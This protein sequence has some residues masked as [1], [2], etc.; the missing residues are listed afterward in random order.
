MFCVADVVYKHLRLCFPKRQNQLITLLQLLK[1]KKN[2]LLM[3]GAIEHRLL[4]PIQTSQCHQMCGWIDE[5]AAFYSRLPVEG[6]RNPS[7]PIE[8]C[9][10]VKDRRLDPSPLYQMLEVFL[11]FIDIQRRQ[12]RLDVLKYGNIYSH[13][14][15][16]QMCTD[17]GDSGKCHFP[18]WGS[19]LY[20]GVQS[21]VEGIEDPNGSFERDA[22]IF[23]SFVTRNLG[24]MHVEAFS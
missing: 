2:A 16:R 11:D 23:V 22:E 5:V 1:F 7:S 15:A 6:R 14:S 12:I 17:V 13:C 8:K 10:R 20:F 3:Q 24:L 18:W 19:H 9:A 4:A 21:Y